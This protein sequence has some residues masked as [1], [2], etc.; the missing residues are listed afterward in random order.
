M[1]GLSAGQNSFTWTNSDKS[2]PPCLDDGGCKETVTATVVSGVSTSTTAPPLPK[3]PA[4]GIAGTGTGVGYTRYSVYFA[5]NCAEA[6]IKVTVT[7]ED[8]VTAKT[9]SSPLPSR[10]L[11]LSCRWRS[12][13]TGADKGNVGFTS[14]KAGSYYY[15]I[16][17]S[18]AAEPNLDTSG[19]GIS[20]TRLTRA[21][22]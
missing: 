21:I 16:V 7:A 5:A 14:S 12:A 18:G 22:T 20:L 11:C 2:N 3:E 4:R 8:G 1:C 15:Q 10:C 19:T 6:T 9:I 17:E 13:R